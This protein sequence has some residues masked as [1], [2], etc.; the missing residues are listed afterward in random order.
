M[1]SFASWSASETGRAPI[2]SGRFPAAA[3]LVTRVENWFSAT[4]T[5]LT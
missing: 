1:F 2:A 5:R 3:E 4:P